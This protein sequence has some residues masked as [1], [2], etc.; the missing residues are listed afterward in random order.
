MFGRPN[1]R[2]HQYLRWIDGP[3]RQNNFTFGINN[4]RQRKSVEL[5][6]DSPLV[7]VQQHSGDMGKGDH[8][9]VGPIFG[10]RQERLGCRTSRP[11]TS[12]C[13]WGRE[14][15][16]HLPVHVVHLVA[17]IRARLQPRAGK[18][19]R[20]RGRRDGQWAALSVVTW[21]WVNVYRKVRLSKSSNKHLHSYSHLFVNR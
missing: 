9:Q 19:R 18:W 20:K 4:M 5:N 3:G 17:E 13:L 21:T 16:L 10:W 14:A 1:A 2:Q 8:V 12:G 11:A 6:A 7:L 15:R